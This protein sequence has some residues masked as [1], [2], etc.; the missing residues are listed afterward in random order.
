MLGIANDI[1]ALDAFI[2][3]TSSSSMHFPLSL[4][5]KT[6]GHQ[7]LT[8]KVGERYQYLFGPRSLSF[9]FYWM[10][11]TRQFHLIFTASFPFSCFKQDGN[12][13]E[14]LLSIQGISK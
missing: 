3:H 9:Q 1:K 12:V 7:G 6:K 4:F 8:P 2:E 10:H 11:Q 13:S 14:I 5:V